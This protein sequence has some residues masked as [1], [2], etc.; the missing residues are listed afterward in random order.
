MRLLW[1]VC[2]LAGI[3]SEAYHV[4]FSPDR[5]RLVMGSA[6]EGTQDTVVKIWD[7]E[8]GAEVCSHG[9][10]HFVKRGLGVVLRRASAAVL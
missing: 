2:T 7:V 4:A 5:K 8:T 3:N 9:G 6:R 1:Q 10:L